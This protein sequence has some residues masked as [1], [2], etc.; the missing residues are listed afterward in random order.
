MS[1]ATYVFDTEPLLGYIYDEPG[2]AAVADRID[3]VHNGET[4]AVMAD[5][6]AAEIC[7]KVARY[8]GKSDGPTPASLRVADR[9]VRALE[10]IGISIDRADWRL[11]GEIKAHGGLSLAD[12][13]AVALA[14]E[15]DA[16]LIVGGDADFHTLPVEVEIERIRDEEA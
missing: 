4:T 15:H 7:Y 9:D 10:R 1:D 14:V 8:Q 3:A 13:F 16:T 2:Y 6:I 11:A 12:A 5:S